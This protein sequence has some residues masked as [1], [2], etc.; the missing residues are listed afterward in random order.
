MKINQAQT[1][2][3]NYHTSKFGYQAMEVF[4]A[5]ALTEN[6][7][8]AEIALFTGIDKSA[9]AGR[10]NELLKAGIIE[11]DDNRHCSVSGVFV[12]TVRVK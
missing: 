3:N 7:T 4:N 10:R 8:I 5:I 11:L 1:A 2:S 12:Q 9:V 6:C